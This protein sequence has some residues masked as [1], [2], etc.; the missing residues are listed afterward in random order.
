MREQLKPIFS[1]LK[2]VC[3]CALF[4]LGF[5]LF[6][7]PNALNAGGLSGLAMVFVQIT[8]VGSVGIVTAIMN[9]PL[10]D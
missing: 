9:L 1:F 5:N 10:A 7:A 3:G 2:I 4:G 6:L 8:G